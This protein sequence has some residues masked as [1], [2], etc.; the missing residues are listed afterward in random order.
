MDSTF[1]PFPEE[2]QTSLEETVGPFTSVSVR[3]LLEDQGMADFMENYEQ[4][5]EDVK[6]WKNEKTPKF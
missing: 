3:L 5:K 6:Q 1:P 4:Y 2:T